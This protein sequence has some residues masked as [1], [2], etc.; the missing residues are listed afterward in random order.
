MR[1]VQDVA[2]AVGGSMILA[3]EFLLEN[4]RDVAKCQSSD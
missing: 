2:E 4:A 3:M 1:D